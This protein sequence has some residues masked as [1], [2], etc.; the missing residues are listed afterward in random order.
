[1]LALIAVG[2]KLS[3]SDRLAVCQGI[4]HGFCWGICLVPMRHLS[5]SESMIASVTYVRVSVECLSEN[6]LCLL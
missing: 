4:C 3:G 1:M 6:L 5:V 2:D